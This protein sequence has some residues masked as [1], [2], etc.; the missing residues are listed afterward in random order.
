M[1]SSTSTGML[2][3]TEV[4]EKVGEETL[5]MDSHD[6]IASHR[7]ATMRWNTEEQ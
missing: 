2:R 1:D 7:S 4:P 3:P 6:A 5:Q